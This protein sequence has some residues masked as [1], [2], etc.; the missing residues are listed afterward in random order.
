MGQSRKV[1]GEKCLVSYFHHMNCRSLK[2][3]GYRFIPAA[4]ST[5]EAAMRGLG[6]GS[7]W[8]K[9]FGHGMPP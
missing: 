8:D 9:A 5:A 3:T 1:L 2:S 7:G 6:P 4:L